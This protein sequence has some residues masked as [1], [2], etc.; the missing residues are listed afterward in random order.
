MARFDFRQV[1]KEAAGSVHGFAVTGGT[2]IGGVL[3]NYNIVQNVKR[4]R[5]IGIGAMYGAMAGG[6][7]GALGSIDEYQYG[8]GNGVFHTVG[9]TVG[10]AGLGGV[11]AGG[12]SA[13]ALAIA[14][15]IR[16]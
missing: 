10:G 2:K 9:G 14:N 8:L 15:G 13:V 16:R 6:T 1:A 7:I 3:N 12:A 4:G 11:A 5:N